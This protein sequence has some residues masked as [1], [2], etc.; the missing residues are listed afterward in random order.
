MKC[1]FCLFVSCLF[2]NYPIDTVKEDE[3]YPLFFFSKDFLVLFIYQRCVELTKMTFD[4]TFVASLYSP[5]KK[6]SRYIQCL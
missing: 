5:K 1:Y 4:S 6:T 2:Y 3:K